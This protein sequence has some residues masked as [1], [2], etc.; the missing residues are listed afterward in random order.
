MDA[1]EYETDYDEAD[2]EEPFLSSSRPSSSRS[3]KSFFPQ[4]SSPSTICILL[5]T[6]VFILSFGG[7]LMGVPAMRIYEDIICH[8]YYENMEGDDRIGLE[9]DI[10][11]GMCK[12][13]EV[14]N[15]LNILLAGLYFLGAIPGRQHFNVRQL[16][17]G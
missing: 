7:H 13:D 1:T 2:E 3:H 17:E 4:T 16:P 8:H 10:T 12:G 6:I 14:Q 15:Q 11:E 9:G 5:F